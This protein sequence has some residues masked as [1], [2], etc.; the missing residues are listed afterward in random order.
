[1]SD[2]FTHPH[3]AT[4]IPGPRSRIL[5]DRQ[6]E[7]ESNAR[8]YPRRL[9]IALSRATGSY[10][11]DV[12]GNVFIDF[13]TGAGVLALG[14]NHP[15]VVEA[16]ERQLRR[17]CHGLDFPT[18]LKD[19]FVT[20]QLSLLP[21]DMRD[22]L[23][24]QFCGPAGANAVDAALKLCKTA[25]GRGEIVSFHG[26]FH[27]STHSA[28]SVTG[29]VAQ[30]APIQ[31]AMQGV[32][33]FP[34]PYAYRWPVTLDPETCGAQCL[35]MLESMLRDPLG[36]IPKPAAVVIEVVQAEGGVIVAPEDFV[37][38]VRE[39]TR[40]LEIPLIVDEIQT[41]CGR[42]GT[43]FA[44]EQYGIEPDV[45]LA[46]KGLGGIGMP[47]AVVMYDRSLDT[48]APGAHTGTFRGNQLAFAAGLAAVR[49]I[50]RDGILEHVRNESRYIVE[51]LDELQREY[52][53]IGD[54]RAAGLMIGM[55]IVDPETG[56]A[57]PEVARALQRAAFERG[58]IVELGGRF[59]AVVRFLPPLNVTRETVDQALDVFR[60]ALAES[61]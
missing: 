34:Y 12:D 35:H 41:G 51:Q 58:L 3:V 9:P 56:D 23:K 44:F 55:E 16:V 57:K 28:M 29:L 61:A 6:A 37:R 15:E 52:P 49:I 54:V 60:E 47:I 10:I 20:L 1:M 24:I 33:F 5:L 2:A 59:D 4:P 31:N 48:W 7:R 17:L 14:H 22:E 27:G 13:L 26:G 30:K 38:G 42:T 46:S 43:W 45:I 50:Q 18:E 25:T 32:H 21:A 11:E 53:L 39:L 19:E 8:T 36:G 40:E